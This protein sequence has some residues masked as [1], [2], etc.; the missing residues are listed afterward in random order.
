PKRINIRLL[1]TIIISLAD[2][3]IIILVLF[4][5]LS[6]FGIEMPIWLIITLVLISS[7]I[8]YILYRT[9]KKNPLLGFDNMI[10]KSGLA[11]S[12]ITR[13]GTVKIGRELWAA[14]AEQDNIE[15]GEEVTVIG[16]TGL[17][18]T[19]IKKSQEELNNQR[20]P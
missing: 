11:I 14:K 20:I 13:E 15:K 3:A 9:L 8:T 2:E 1:L 7:A 16:Q 17:K 18:L 6:R 10:G 4:F 12:K 5:V 19:V